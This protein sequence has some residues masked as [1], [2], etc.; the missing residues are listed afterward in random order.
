[1][2]TG[3]KIL[4]AVSLLTLLTTFS[5]V[6]KEFDTPEIPDPCLADPGLTANLDII[7]IKIQYSSLEQVIPGV[8]K[9]PADSNYVLEATVISTDEE[10]NFYKEIYLADKDQNN[11]INAIKMSIDGTELYNDFN[12]GQVVQI[13]L[14]D[15]YVSYDSQSKMYELGMG[16]YEG[17]G[18]G[19]IP[20]A[21]IDQVMFRKSCP[22]DFEPQTK[23]IAELSEIYNGELIKLENVQFNALDT[24]ATFADASGQITENR[25]LEDCTGA[26]IIVRTSGYASFAGEDVPNDKGTFIG[27][28]GMYGSDK[29]LYI[30]KL[31]EVQLDG[32]RCGS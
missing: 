24:N 30:R 28:F 26:T 23:T 11:N 15:L 10:G 13:K 18:I 9:F 5:C 19:R 21:L 16:L 12:V 22:K 4:F 14:S 20:V 2:K 1:M 7:N 29:Q 17:T 6:K 8:K 32:P 25:I 31:E 3:F 27:I